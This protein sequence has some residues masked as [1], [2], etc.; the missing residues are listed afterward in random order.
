[1]R[2][3]EGL[4]DCGPRFASNTFE[5][6]ENRDDVI[7]AAIRYFNEAL[8]GKGST[9]IAISAT[10]A[11]RG[12][13]KSHLVDVLCR[14]GS[15]NELFPGH[16]NKRLVPVPIS[17]NGPQDYHAQDFPDAQSHVIARL[18]HRGFF[19]NV[20]WSDFTSCTHKVI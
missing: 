17:F 4:Y 18:M 5:T 20:L 8:K 1:M 13:G 15:H 6:T 9:D 11:S 19:P 7:K 16:N 12:T 2:L 3:R 14:L 10:L